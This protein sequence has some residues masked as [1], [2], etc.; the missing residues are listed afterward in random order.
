[1]I[2]SFFKKE[3]LAR[4]ASTAPRTLARDL[5]L[6]QPCWLLRRVDTRSDFGGPSVALSSDLTGRD[7]R[8]RHCLVPHTVPPL[9]GLQLLLL[10]SLTRKL[11]G[12]AVPLED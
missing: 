1:M 6:N 9:P 12:F 4:W 10:A 5:V 7:L 3:K 11:G 8:G 2:Y